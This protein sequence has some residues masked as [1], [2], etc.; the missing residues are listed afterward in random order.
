M[1]G[2][3]QVVALQLITLTTADGKFVAVNP[4]EIVAFRA[5]RH[6]DQY[7]AGAKCLIF[8]SDAK[9]ISAAND[10]TEVFELLKP[11]ISR[12]GSDAYE[13]Q[14]ESSRRITLPPL[15]RPNNK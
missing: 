9:F 6:A 10:C 1:I 12:T 11:I 5:P 14:S 13:L 3:W 7:V 8:T 2:L 15:P 4:E